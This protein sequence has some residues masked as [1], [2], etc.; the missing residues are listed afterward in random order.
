LLERARSMESMRIVLCLCSSQR[1]HTQVIFVAT[2]SH[3][4]GHKH[5][6]TLTQTHG[7]ITWQPKDHTHACSIATTAIEF[8]MGRARLTARGTT[9]K[10]TTP[11]RSEARSIVLSAG[12]ARQPFSAWAATSA[13]SAGP[14][15]DP[16]MSSPMVARPQA[17]MRPGLRTAHPSIHQPTIDATY[18][19]QKKP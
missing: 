15:H 7:A 6:V 14:R 2:H 12:T 3:W 16:I 5:T 19:K 18:K 1:V 11:T 13:H 17:R 8:Q 10:N 4:E 9:R